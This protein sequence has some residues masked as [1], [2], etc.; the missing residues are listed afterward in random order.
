MRSHSGKYGGS[1]IRLLQLQHVQHPLLLAL[2]DE[3]EHLLEAICS[4]IGVVDVA[5][6][7][8]CLIGVSITRQGH[9]RA[10]E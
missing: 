10:T 3:C 1:E 8:Y 4:K 5:Y 2:G 6:C 9:R 7:G